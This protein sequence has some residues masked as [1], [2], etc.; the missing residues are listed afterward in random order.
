MLPRCP[1]TCSPPFLPVPAN[2]DP[3]WKV[4]AS[5]L[6]TQGVGHAFS[7]PGRIT[8]GKGEGPVPCCPGAERRSFAPCPLPSLPG[9]GQPA[10]SG[11]SHEDLGATGIFLALLCDHSPRLRGDS[12]RLL[13][14]HPH[15]RDPVSPQSPRHMHIPAS[16][17]VG[18]AH[19]KAWLR[20]SPVFSWISFRSNSERP[21]VPTVMIKPPRNNR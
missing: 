7:S 4:C 2:E 17:D 13:P 5:F 1:L 20:I 8:P 10:G 19:L 11:W 6:H 16:Q 14:R 3:C 9:R 21:P 18:C 15:F 12:G